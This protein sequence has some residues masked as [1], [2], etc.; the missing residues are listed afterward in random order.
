MLLVLA[1]LFAACGSA[2]APDGSGSSAE[3]LRV[4]IAVD[5]P[6]TVKAPNGDLEGFNPE[7]VAMFGKHAQRPIELIETGWTGIVAGLQANKYSMIGAD[8]NETEER[9]K[10]IDF[11]KP[12]FQSGVTWFVPQDSPLRTLD[13]LNR[14]DVTIAFTA[15]SDLETATLQTLPDATYRSLPNASI[16]EL[17][18][19]VESRRSGAMANSNYVAQALIERYGYRAIP[20]LDEQASGVLPVGIGWAVQKGD[21]ALL[22]QIDEFLTTIEQ[23]GDLAALQEKYLTADAFAESIGL[24]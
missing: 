7:L 16:G 24:S 3:P 23:N 4:G 13:D 9:A 22:A 8:L 15:G 12:Y 10:V 14:E 2:D 6:W 1:P 5:P 11:S 21:A 17:I 20:S 18:S 19:E